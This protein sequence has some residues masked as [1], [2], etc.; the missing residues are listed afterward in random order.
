MHSLAKRAEKEDADNWANFDMP[1]VYEA[2]AK[3]HAAAGNKDECRKYIQMSKELIYKL[4]DKQD[5]A[6]CQG[7]LD[8]VKC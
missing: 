6:I 8:K 7:E 1:F 3:A 5:K 2:I 4:E